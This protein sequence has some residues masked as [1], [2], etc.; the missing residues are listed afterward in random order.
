[1]LD[2]HLDRIYLTESFEKGLP[3][4]KA[5]AKAMITAMK[6][7]NLFKAHE[8]FVSLPDVS[9]NNLM[10]AAHKPDKAKFHKYHLE[11][12]KMVKGDRTDMQK[13]FILT[14][15]SLKMMQASVKEPKIS[16]KIDNL[17]SELNKLAKKNWAVFL[18]SGVVV[19]LLMRYIGIMFIHMPLI[20]T[21]VILGGAGAAALLFWLG[22]QFFVIRIVLG[23]YFKLKGLK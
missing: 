22:I 12:K 13:V 19:S 15:G 7:G 20:G 16:K 17:L 3:V 11:A 4:I 18:A 8:L 21:F 14:Y 23:A 1:M 10:I 9:I 6:T 2:D 5:R